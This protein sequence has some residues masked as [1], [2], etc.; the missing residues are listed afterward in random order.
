MTHLEKIFSILEKDKILER[1]K[2][3]QGIAVA[4]SGGADSVALSRILHAFNDLSSEKFPLALVHINYGLRGIDSNRDAEFVANLAKKFG[5]QLF[6]QVKNEGLFPRKNQG[7]Q[8]WARSLRYDFF[9]ELIS[10][11]WIVA[12]AHHLEDLAETILLRMTRGSS[13]A[14]LIGMRKWQGNYYRPL[15]SVSKNELL[16]CLTTFDQSYC[17]DSSNSSLKYDRNRIRLQVLPVLE[18]LHYGAAKRIVELAEEV[19]NIA[20]KRIDYFGKISAAYIDCKSLARQ[21]FIDF[22]K[23][24]APEEV[25]GLFFEVFKLPR[26]ALSRKKIA[27]IA[28]QVMSSAAKNSVWSLDMDKTWR[29]IFSKQRLSY[30]LDAELSKQ[31]GSADIL[32]TNHRQ[33][34]KRQPLKQVEFKELLFPGGCVNFSSSIGEVKVLSEAPQSDPPC[35]LRI[36]QPPSRRALVWWL[37]PH[38]ISLKEIFQANCISLLDRETALVFE[39]DSVAFGLFIRNKYYICTNRDLQLQELETD[40]FVWPML[41][42]DSSLRSE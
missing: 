29:V 21:F 41:E 17:E 9:Q 34:Q 13:A 15:L 30:E 19:D 26:E 7:V 31:S 6:S 40:C 23:E 2:A 33:R 18:E 12:L 24:F 1:V 32:V 20:Q 28:T 14:K 16:A 42:R 39:V 25:V 5:C 22:A 4:C 36:Y 35:E 37:R 10:Q 8:E 27:A 38:K 3:Y 11:G